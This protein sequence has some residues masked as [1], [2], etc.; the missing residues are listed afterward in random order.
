MPCS[1]HQQCHTKGRHLHRL[2]VHA[3]HSATTQRAQVLSRPLAWAAAC[4]TSW[5]RC[6]TPSAETCI[7][8]SGSPTRMSVP[9]HR[10]RAGTLTPDIKMHCCWQAASWCSRGTP[11]RNHTV[12]WMASGCM[13]CTMVGQRALTCIVQHDVRPELLKRSLQRCLCPIEVLS[14]A[15]ACKQQCGSSSG[16]KQKLSAMSGM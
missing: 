1:I 9:A 3:A 11:P 6:W 15:C 5:S 2:S 8:P 13:P 4:H 7:C 10:S 12:N 16:R 14:V